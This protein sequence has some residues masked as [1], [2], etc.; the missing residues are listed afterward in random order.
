Y[1]EL[2]YQLL[3]YIYTTVEETTRTGIPLMRP[4]F[5]EYPQ[6][7][8]LYNEIDNGF[9]L[10]YL[11][12]RDLLVAPR[13]TEMQDNLQIS[14]PPGEWYDFWTGKKAIPGKEIQ[15]NPAL[16]EVPVFARAGAII[17]QQPVVQ[18]TAQKPDG[19]LHLLVYPGDDCRGSVYLDDGVSLKYKSGEYLR[20]NYTCQMSAEGVSVRISPPQGTFSSWWSQV[21]LVIFGIEQRPRQIM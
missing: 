4:I 10:E 18:F 14:L 9:L 20:V 1:I 8:T 19:P 7:E 17:P 12:G 15:V 21:R 11:F 13:E 16:D 6:A 5:L 2:R 3:P